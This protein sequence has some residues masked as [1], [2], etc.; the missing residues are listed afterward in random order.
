MTTSPGPDLVSFPT[1]ARVSNSSVSEN[2]QLGRTRTRTLTN[3]GI[4]DTGP[5]MNGV[6]SDPGQTEDRGKGKENLPHPL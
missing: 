3:E 5:E 4:Y 6:R 2:T 1:W